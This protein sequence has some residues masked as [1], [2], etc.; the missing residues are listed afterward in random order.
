M[1]SVIIEGVKYTEGDWVVMLKTPHGTYKPGDIFQIHKI[2]D[3]CFSAIGKD[4]QEYTGFHLSPS[5]QRL[6]T[7]E[8][9]SKVQ[10][11]KMF[12]IF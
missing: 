11:L 5:F 4:N 12:P 9:L 7:Y 6:A 2:A 10:E 1:K 8:E 3:K